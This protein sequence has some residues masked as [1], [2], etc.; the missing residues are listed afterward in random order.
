MSWHIGP[1][2][3]SICNWGKQSPWTWG[4]GVG[5]SPQNI[6]RVSDDIVAQVVEAGPHTGRT[7][8]LDKMLRNFDQGVHPEAQHTGYYN[9]PDMMVLGMPGLTAEQNRL[10]MALRAISAAP[11]SSSALIS[12]SSM[13]IL[14]QFAAIQT[15]FPSTRTRSVCKG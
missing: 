15:Q 6:W 11:P 8:A 3:N 10:H 14:W 9:D 12:P 13:R 4:P 7:V 1:L 2:Y 5:G